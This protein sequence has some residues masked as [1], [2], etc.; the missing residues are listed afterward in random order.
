VVAGNITSFELEGRRVVGYLYGPEWWGRG[1]ATAALARFLAFET[2][3]PLSGFVAA[4]NAASARVLEKCGFERV[5]EQTGPH[6]VP[7][8]LLTLGA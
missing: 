3:R 2:T 8:I 4:S 1:I 7:E 6:G 5:L